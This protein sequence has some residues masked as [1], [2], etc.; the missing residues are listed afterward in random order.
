ME[1][2][3]FGVAEPL[4]GVS[5]VALREDGEL[6]LYGVGE[7]EEEGE[8][9]QAAVALAWNAVERHLGL[10]QEL[11]ERF[12][13]EPDDE[14]RA[15]L[16]RAVEEALLRASRELFA[17]SRRRKKALGVGM[18]LLVHV[19]REAVVAHVGRGQIFLLRR[20]LLHRLAQ[21]RAGRSHPV[22]GEESSSLNAPLMGGEGELEID[23]LC[24]ESWPAD[25]LVLVSS[26][27]AD[28]VEDNEA[29]S[30]MAGLSIQKCARALV[31]LGQEKGARCAL[32]A[33]ALRVPGDSPGLRPRGLPL[34][35]VLRQMSLLAYCSQGELLDV[36]AVARPQRLP[37]GWRI[38]S[39]GDAGREL[40][41]LVA[42][43][44]SVVKDG[45]GVARLGPGSSFGEM[46]MLDDPRRSATVEV[47]RA[48]DLLVI[49][50]DA[51]FGLLKS[52]QAL[53][54]KILWNMLLRVSGNLRATTEMMARLVGTGGLEEVDW[55]DTDWTV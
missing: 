35:P 33:M 34:L 22:K 54:V 39:E 24:L 40:Y 52:D 51:F 19:G 3:V 15:A 14:L 44:V 26:A 50:R 36:A 41:L 45:I 25:R 43:E 9:G 4:A 30:F 42:G 47:L 16:L 8:D 23:S 17:F 29:R 1:F 28:L 10:H 49:P 5:P 53:A 37:A 55:E 2:S 12:R 46:C 18:G 20:D 27:L 7:C 31:A 38:F 48:S 13:A 11:I 21:H 32:G 6:G